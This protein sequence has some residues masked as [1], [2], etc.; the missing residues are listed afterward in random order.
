MARLDHWREVL[1]HLPRATRAR[2]RTSVPPTLD[3]ADAALVVVRVRRAAGPVSR[4]P[5]RSRAGEGVS[6]MSGRRSASRLP[7]SNG[8][9]PATG[10]SGCL[11]GAERP[12]PVE[13]DVAEDGRCR[14]VTFQGPPAPSPCATRSWTSDGARALAWPRT[15]SASRLR[16]HVVRHRR[17]GRP[18]AGAR[19]GGGR[20]SARPAARKR[21]TTGL[22][23]EHPTFD[24]P[25]PDICLPRAAA[26]RGADARNAVVMSNGYSGMLDRSPRLRP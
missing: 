4:R 19:A 5:R 20:P 16:R 3:E 7:W 21:L 22:P 11:G 14:S 25:G 23:V 15:R 17:R 13:A 2:T 26:L 18:G 1:L 10:G 12:V 8:L 24:Y 9:L 6:A